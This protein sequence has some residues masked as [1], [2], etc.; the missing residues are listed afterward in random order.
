MLIKKIIDQLGSAK[1]FFYSCAWLIILLV[2]GTIA[3]KYIGLYQAQNIYFSSW[4][5]WVNDLVPIPGGYIPMGVIFFGL[6]AKIIFKSP[7]KKRTIGIY[8][9]HI[10]ALM[11]LVGGL[12]TA[13]F[14]QEG[15]MTIPEGD[16]VSFY[17]DY[18][19]VELAIIDQSN[20]E[21][22]TTYAFQDGYLEEGETIKHEKLP[23]RLEVLKYCRNCKIH[24]KTTVANSNEKLIGFAKRFKLSNAILKIEDSENRAGVVFRLIP[25]DINN[26][27]DS[28]G[29]YSVIE[30]MPVE[31]TLK[32]EGKDYIIGL[33][34]QRNHLPFSIKLIDFM[35]ENHASTAMAKSYK[36]EV[37]LVDNN[38]NQRNL[39]QMNDPLRYKGY[40][41]YQ[42]SFMEGESQTTVL[43]VVK[44]VGRLFPYISSIIMCFGLLIHLILASPKLF[45][46]ES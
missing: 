18:H 41:F 27:E 29:T 26:K 46:R 24:R 25:N 12:L 11:L 34:H 37:I 43:A 44:N 28:V 14:G 2:Q 32:F 13:M 31:Q 7:L 10:G 4:I 39:I 33:R 16:T 6:A 35:K 45:K 23:F 3:Q 42:A 20:K 19:K 5:I 30:F 40:T 9:T 36:S 21:N 1:F 22:D 15:S 8:I 17:T 38:I